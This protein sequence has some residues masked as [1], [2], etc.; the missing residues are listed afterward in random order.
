MD[1]IKKNTCFFSETK[2]YNIQVPYYQRDYAQGRNDGG[3]IDNIRQVFVGELFQA[4]KSTQ[5]M[6]TCHL[7]L[8]FG[9]Y[10]DNKK[11]FIAVDGQ[12]RLTTVFLLHWYVAWKENK[13]SEYLFYLKRFSWD[14]RSFSSQ[15]VNLLLSGEL[16]H[17]GNVEDAIKR[18]P[19]YFSIWENDPTVKGMVTM[20]KEIE[21]KY[22]KDCSCLCDHLFSDGCKIKFDI[23]RLGKNTDRKT[24]LKMNSRGRSLTTFELF[25]SK[26]L[27]RYKNSFSNKIDNKWLDF[28]LKISNTGN[29]FNDPDIYFMNFINE[30]SYLLLNLQKEEKNHTEDYKEFVNAKI[31]ENLTDVPFISFENYHA[32][33]DGY[34]ETFEKTFDWIV[35]NYDQIRLI[36]DKFRFSGSRFY[37]DAIIKDNNPNYS[38]RAKLFGTIKFAELT[39]FRKIEEVLFERWTRVVRNLV[40]NSNIDAANIG[41]ICKAI[42]KIDDSDIC[43]YLANTG[44]LSA[45]NEEQ[46]AEEVI[47]SKKIKENECWESRFEEAETYAFF[48]GAI[49][50]LFPIENGE[51]WSEYEKKWENAKLYF[52]ENG[53][54]DTECVKYRTD[55]ILI[56][57]ALHHAEDFWRLI[58]PKK[59]VFD[60]EPN[61]WK[62]NILLNNDWKKAVHQL[63]SGELDIDIR[64]D[65]CL[66]YKDIYSSSLM[67]YVSNKQIGSR[68]RWRHSNYRALYRE[69][70]RYDGIVLDDEQ[71]N[72]PIYR[73]RILSELYKDKKIKSNNKIEGCDFFN[74]WDVV[75]EYQ[76]YKFL[77]DDEGNVFLLE[78]NE[79]KKVSDNEFYYFNVGGISEINIFIQKLNSLIS[80][81]DQAIKG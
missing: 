43:L 77:W 1:N 41:R 37:L 14:T 62:S 67:N 15:F 47:K 12:Q 38:H 22:P 71:R 21:S 63:M 23:L 52:D 34:V 65:D 40:A 19:N 76:K 7:G 30:Y 13:L 55:A 74:G 59:C 44:Q 51:D 56:K 39:E 35:D 27:D 10:D 81:S 4:I 46:I 60:N 50:F 8:V 32:V 61:T 64:D 69:R 5:D 20:L 9:S 24:Y 36:D 11:I 18:S 25:K 3:R 57:A 29:K 49:R 33:F 68:I 28:M 26:L 75:F 58:E 70:S 73:N 2:E 6:F 17:I 72:P 78:N 80:D 53:V 16:E 31:K 48:K 66:I 54:K 42:D 79:K 45:F